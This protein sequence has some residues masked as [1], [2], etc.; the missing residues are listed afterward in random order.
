MGSLLAKEDDILFFIDVDMAVTPSLAA[1]CRRHVSKSKFAWYPIPFSQYDPDRLCVDDGIV[2]SDEGA[3]VA[4]MNVNL[5]VE[6]SQ[7]REAIARTPFTV[8]EER[9]F[10]RNFGYGITCMYKSDFAKSGGFDLTIEG[11]G[12]EDV[13]LYRAVLK[14]GINAFRSNDADLVHIFHQKHCSADLIG[15][16]ARACQSSKKSHYASQ[17]CLSKTYFKKHEL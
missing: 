12:E 15:E 7:V 10:W 5:A 6:E 9:G 4:D 16:Q 13:R 11:W 2:R 17:K 8:S 3:L 14:S 1:Q